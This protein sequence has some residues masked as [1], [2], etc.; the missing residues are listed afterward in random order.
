[1]PGSSLG[2]EFSWLQSDLKEEGKAGC[3]MQV[4][5][6]QVPAVQLLSFPGLRPMCVCFYKVIITVVQLHV[7]LLYFFLISAHKH[8]PCL[9]SYHTF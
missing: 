6:V 3:V 1:M 5:R 2:E 8:F 7:L 4:G 9:S